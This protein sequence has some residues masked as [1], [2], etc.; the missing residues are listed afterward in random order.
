MN[1]IR[2]GPIDLYGCQEARERLEPY[3][4]GELPHGE[5]RRVDFHL[6]ICRECAPLFRFEMRLDSHVRQ[7]LGDVDTPPDLYTKMQGVLRRA[8]NTEDTS[9]EL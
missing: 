5:R 8:R 4:D 7:G 3:I 2:I 9:S 1:R 6:V